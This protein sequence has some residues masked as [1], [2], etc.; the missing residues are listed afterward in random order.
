MANVII[1]SSKLDSLAEHIAD[2]A[3]ASLP[4]TI[5]GMEAAVD[6]LE[7]ENDF[8]VTINYTTDSE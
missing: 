4:L 8:I 3:E 7:L 1:N 2:K 5:A 6:G